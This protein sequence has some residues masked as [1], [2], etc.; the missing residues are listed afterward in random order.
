MIVL[1][2]SENKLLYLQSI[3]IGI[4]KTIKQIKENY[5]AI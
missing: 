1:H 5:E 2:V 4:T 3:K